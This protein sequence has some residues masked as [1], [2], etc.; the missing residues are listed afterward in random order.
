MRRLCVRS[1]SVEMSD[2][3]QQIFRFEI[4]THIMRKKAHCAHRKR[5]QMEKCKLTMAAFGHANAEKL[6]TTMVKIAA[7][8]NR[9]MLAF[10]NSHRQARQRNTVSAYII[11]Y[12]W[13]R[14]GLRLLT[15]KHLNL[16]RDKD[17]DKECST[18]YLN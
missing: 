15:T 16:S 4:C 1:K 5:T 9:L 2:T 17:S 11:K 12:L 6:Q 14:H 7:N 10:E 18:A 3:F 8:Y 13:L